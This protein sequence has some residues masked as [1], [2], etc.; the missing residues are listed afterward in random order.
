MTTRIRKNAAVLTDNEVQLLAKAFAGIQA[1]IHTDPTS[2][3]ALAN[4]HGI[5]V[6]TCQHHMQ[7]FLPWHRKYVRTFE[8]AL[9]AIPGC[10][11]VS[12][13]RTILTR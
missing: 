2:F 9:R 5:G 4:W 8:D 7:L 12:Y 1:K 11:N 13:K 10:E 3:F 6:N